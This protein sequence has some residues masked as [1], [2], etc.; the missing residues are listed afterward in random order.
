MRFNVMLLIVLFRS[1]INKLTK[2]YSDFESR[3]VRTVSYSFYNIRLKITISF[4]T[5]KKNVQHIRNFLHHTIRPTM[6]TMHE[7][8]L[9]AR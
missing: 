8:H 6:Q 2:H 5:Y 1:F 7:Y 3:T 4:S 9:Q